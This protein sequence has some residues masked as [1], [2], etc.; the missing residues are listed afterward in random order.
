MK[1]HMTDIVVSRLKEPGTYYD[2]TTPAFGLRV[3]KNRKTWFVIRGRE[4]LRKNIG[5]YPAVSLA[6]ARKEARKLLSEELE[7]GS[8]IKFNAAYET[9]KE[10]IQTKKPRT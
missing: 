6:D 7:K 3:G 8:R 5:R 1:L 9:F 4:R 2:A 10:A